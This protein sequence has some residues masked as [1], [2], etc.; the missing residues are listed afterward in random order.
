MKRFI[1]LIVSLVVLTISVPSC[2][3]MS[4]S[5]AEYLTGVAIG[6]AAAIYL[7]EKSNN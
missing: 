3:S 5:D 4:K 1:L 7:T 6:T 2:G